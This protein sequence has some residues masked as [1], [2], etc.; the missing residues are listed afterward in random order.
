MFFFLFVQLPSFS[1][2]P[3]RPPAVCEEITEPP[4]TPCPPGMNNL[5]AI[6]VLICFR[7]AGTCEFD[8]E[9]GIY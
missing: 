9:V 5:E 7:I 4:C 2:F 8:L 3:G 1:G 6:N